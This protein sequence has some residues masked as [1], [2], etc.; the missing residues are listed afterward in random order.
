MSRIT[1]SRPYDAHYDATYTNPFTQMNNDPRVKSTLSSS[2]MVSGTSRYKYFR[3]PVMPRVNAVPPEI[4]LAPTVTQDPMKPVEH[5]PEPLIKNAEVQTIFRDSEA[6]TIPYTPEYTIPGDTDPE[7]L[8]LKNLTFENGGLPLGKKEID[9]VEYARSKRDV[10]SNLPPF[11]DEA[12]LCFRKKLMEQQEMREFKLREAE[13]DTKREERLIKLQKALEDRNETS[14]FLSSQRVEAMRAVRL[15]EREK[16]L[17]KIRNKRIKVL[18]RLALARNTADPILSDGRSRDIIGD[19]FDRASTIY[20]PIKRDGKGAKPEFAKFDVASRTA[21]LDVMNNILD[22]ESAIPPSLLP[23]TDHDSFSPE[24][25]KQMSKTAPAGLKGSRAAEERMTSA[26]RRQLRDTKRDLEEMHQI[27]LNKK[28]EAQT[29]AQGNNKSRGGTRSQE[30]PNKT[31]GMDDIRPKSTAGTKTV[32]GR[33]TTPDLTVDENGN[34]ISDNIEFYNSCV[35][36]QRLIRGR[37]IQNIMFENKLRRSE[38]INEI[39]V[40][41]EQL[42]AQSP[43][44]AVVVNAEL[45]ALREIRLK[46][47]TIDSIVGGVTS[48]VIYNA[49]QDY[50]RTELFDKMEGLIRDACDERRDVEAKESGRRQKENMQ[51]PVT[52]D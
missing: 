20:A 28:R 7:V 34:Q 52:S 5:E 35:F 47:T 45:K 6:Q 49:S 2:N 1:E 50:E 23:P 3:R 12:S 4:L 48:N 33:P 11:T 30:N 51:Y 36:L 32:K 24:K 22:L 9:M 39:R 17:A 10:E 14:E 13:M 27:L 37:A 42:L 8:L 46:E 29:S 38:L 18:R 40:A 44:S 41:D 21:P 15:D 26:A 43:K 19:Y 31:L 25:V 16:L